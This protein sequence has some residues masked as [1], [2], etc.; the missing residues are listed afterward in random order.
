[1]ESNISLEEK[2]Y[3][4]KLWKRGAK[5]RFRRVPE[6]GSQRAPFCRTLEKLGLGLLEEMVWD[7]SEDNRQESAVLRSGLWVSRKCLSSQM[8]DA[9][10]PLGSL[11]GLFRNVERYEKAK[12]QARGPSLCDRIDLK[13]LDKPY[14]VRA[15]T[16][17]LRKP[18]R[19]QISEISG[20][21]GSRGPW[22]PRSQGL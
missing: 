1:M 7:R 9:S 10:M 13:R 20:S 8:R 4:K 14:Q 3:K 6:T 16:C 15:G 19:Y 12:T 2:Y 21:Q 22:V 18:V 5:T 17:E 11:L